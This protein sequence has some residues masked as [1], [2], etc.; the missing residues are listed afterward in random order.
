M[1][2]SEMSGMGAMMAWMTLGTVGLI[3][4]VV[5]VTVGILTLFQR[6]SSDQDQAHMATSPDDTLKQ[7]YAAGEIEEAE[8][9]RRRAGLAG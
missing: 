6:R 3:V 9:V 2:D 4:F 8:Y 1:M 7:R 5:V